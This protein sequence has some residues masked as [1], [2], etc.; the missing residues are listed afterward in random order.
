MKHKMPKVARK[1]WKKFTTQEEAEK[2]CVS[3]NSDAWLNPTLK[4]CR[5]EST[6]ASGAGS[7]LPSDDGREA[8]TPRR[9]AG[10]L[11]S[12][13]AKV[14][15]EALCTIFTVPLDMPLDAV[16]VEALDWRQT[17]PAGYTRVRVIPD[18]GA[19]RSCAPR[20]M[21]PEYQIMPSE[22][23]RKGVQFVSA[24]GNTIKNEGEQRLPMVS[25]EGVW[26][27]HLWQIADVTRPLLSIG[28][29]ADEGNIMGFGPKG[30]FILNLETNAIRWFPRTGGTYELDMYLPPPEEAA[31]M[32]GFTRPAWS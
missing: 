24:S 2:M 19:K 3:C 17:G 27:N 14:I 23:S 18:T 8:E 5:C 25:E 21:A 16:P 9:V 13:E 1:R 29:V 11:G 7:L 12:D 6:K 20:S 31:K 15:K 26:S 22:A 28:E 10:Q 30:G 32:T 4:P